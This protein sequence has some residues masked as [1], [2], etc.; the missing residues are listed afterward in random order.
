ME[1]P[2][3]GLSF[4]PLFVHIP[5][6]RS[7]ITSIG[8]G[9]LTRAA[10]PCSAYHRVQ[11][12]NSADSGRRRGERRERRCALCNQ[13]RVKR[14]QS[15]GSMSHNFSATP[16]IEGQRGFHPYPTRKGQQSRGLTSNKLTTFTAAGYPACWERTHRTLHVVMNILTTNLY[17]LDQSL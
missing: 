7:P 3:S 12:H 2:L 16:V 17:S 5:V 11:R 4:F 6:K 10:A 1:Q 14:V 9:G 15:T 8:Y 13:Q